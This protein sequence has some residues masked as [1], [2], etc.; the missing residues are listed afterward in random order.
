MS[1][2]ELAQHERQLQQRLPTPVALIV[3]RVSPEPSIKDTPRAKVSYLAI[4]RNH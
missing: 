2:S 3:L 4:F 1:L